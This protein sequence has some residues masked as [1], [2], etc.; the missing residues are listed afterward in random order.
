MLAA[1]GAL[2]STTD[3]GTLADCII[4]VCSRLLPGRS[5]GLL[6]P[7]PRMERFVPVASSPSGQDALQTHELARR[8]PLARSLE[9]DGRPQ[10]VIVQGGVGRRRGSRRIGRNADSLRVRDDLVGIL[11]IGPSRSGRR[12]GRDEI[13]IAQRSARRR[14]CVRERGAVRQPARRLHRARDPSELVAR[15]GRRP[16]RRALNLQDVLRKV[17]GGVIEAWTS[18]SDRLL[19]GSDH[20]RDLPVER[21]GSP[22]DTAHPLPRND[23]GRQAATA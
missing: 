2:P 1:M 4:D 21:G 6:L 17:C 22:D 19:G 15:S 10:S 20:T 5:L 3:S 9:R 14:R 12:L 13:K 23:R 16:P 18:G 8:S 11:V 7:E